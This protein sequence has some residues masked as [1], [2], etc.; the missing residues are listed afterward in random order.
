MSYQTVTHLYGISICCNSVQLIH[1]TLAFVIFVCNSSTWHYHLSS[2][3]LSHLHV[4]S[5]SNLGISICR[6]HVQLIYMALA[7]VIFVQNSFTLQYFRA[8]SI[9]PPVTLHPKAA[10]ETGLMCPAT[11]AVSNR[12]HWPSTKRS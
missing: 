9:I 12:S 1:T 7:F 6:N 8:I 2:L 3:H 5:E 10:A 11:S 4:I